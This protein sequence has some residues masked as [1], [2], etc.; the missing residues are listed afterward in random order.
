[1]NQLTYLLT[2]KPHPV[3][4]YR[5]PPKPLALPK[6][7]TEAQRAVTERIKSG[8]QAEAE[9]R[10]RELLTLVR[11]A[12]TPGITVKQLKENFPHH[13]NSIQRMLRTM[14]ERRLVVSLYDA[15]V[16]KGGMANRWVA[17]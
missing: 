9:Q 4:E 6:G 11:D 5:E 7:R 13:L 8:R 10:I 2:G 17:K 16:C 15:K 1:M 14:R 12:G 3:P